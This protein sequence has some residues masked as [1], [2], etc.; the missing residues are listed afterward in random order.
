MAGDRRN[1]A[2]LITKQSIPTPLSRS[3]LRPA[4]WAID[5]PSAI[6]QTT[7]A[8]QM[9]LCYAIRC[10][11]DAG[12]RNKYAR[13]ARKV[14]VPIKARNSHLAKSLRQ[15]GRYVSPHK[16]GA[17]RTHA[18]R[19]FSWLSRYSNNW[20]HSPTSQIAHPAGRDVWA[21]LLGRNPRPPPPAAAVRRL[22]DVRSGIGTAI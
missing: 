11:K 13:S 22:H 16:N 6:A 8:K 21:F 15:L 4:H 17:A 9:H 14:G 5:A 20:H 18:S 7:P 3:V 19:P 12:M 1:I 10:N 2:A